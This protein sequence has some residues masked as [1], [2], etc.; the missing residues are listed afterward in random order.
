MGERQR[1]I[2][3]INW[4]I[5]G[6]NVVQLIKKIKRKGYDEILQMTEITL[7]SS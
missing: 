4:S 5:S 6:L 3:T 1:H 2:T 7:R